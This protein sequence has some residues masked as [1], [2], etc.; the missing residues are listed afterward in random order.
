MLQQI[1]DSR[2]FRWG[3]H[4]SIKKVV[5]L[6]SVRSLDTRKYAHN[7]SS[8]SDYTMPFVTLV[9]RW[10]LAANYTLA[11][12]FFVTYYSIPIFLTVLLTNSSTT[13]H[14]SSLNS[15]FRIVLSS[16]FHTVIVV[17][18]VNALCICRFHDEVHVLSSSV[19]GR[20]TLAGWGQVQLSIKPRWNIRN[21]ILQS[22][23]FIRRRQGDASRL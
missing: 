2:Y 17:H 4:V 12:I 16:T 20:S 6:S 18:I 11:S 13:T 19:V 5:S 3:E 14:L 1:S 9:E 10:D 15:H 8:I 22:A 21:H 7:V 23:F